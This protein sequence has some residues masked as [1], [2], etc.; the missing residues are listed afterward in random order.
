MAVLGAQYLEFIT[1]EACSSACAH[2]VVPPGKIIV[3]LGRMMY[4]APT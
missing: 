1:L 2:M 4:R 3:T